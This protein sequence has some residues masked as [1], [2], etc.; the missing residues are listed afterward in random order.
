[1]N[2]IEIINGLIAKNNYKTYLEIGVRD[3][4]CFHAVK[5]ETKVGVDPDP[6]S[7]ATVKQTSDDFFYKL[8]VS[9][10]KEDI[11]IPKRYD[12]IFI[13]GLHHADQVEQD[14]I[15]ALE[16]L[17]LGG[18]IVM[19]D[20]LPT[21]KFMQEIPMRPDHNEWT[22]DTWRAYLKNRM[23][24]D[25]LEMCVVD[26]D[27]GCGIIR[28]GHQDLLQLATTTPGGRIS[29]EDFDKN[30]VKWMNVISLQQFRQKYL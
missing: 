30:R 15:N 23:E 8:T 28:P 16:H 2:R 11:G 24:R 26:T 21:S 19:H 7:A 5:C 1:M 29:Y 9:P 20:C 13:D 10:F 25:D 3:G 6:A 17:T 22:G 4:S 12:I 14:I 27:W 18:T